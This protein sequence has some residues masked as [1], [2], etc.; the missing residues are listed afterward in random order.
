MRSRVV[1]RTYR[2]EGSFDPKARTLNLTIQTVNGPLL[3]ARERLIVTNAVNFTAPAQVDT[4]HK[5]ATE[6]LRFHLEGVESLLE[7]SVLIRRTAL[8]ADGRLLEDGWDI[9][10]A[11]HDSRVGVLEDH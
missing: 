5:D 9:C 8:R 4:L 2:V 11:L 3:T 10:S 7:A 1:G 6:D